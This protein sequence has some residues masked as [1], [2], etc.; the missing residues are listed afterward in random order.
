MTK[1]QKNYQGSL[2]QL[3]SM[4]PEIYQP[5]FN[6]PELSKTVSRDCYD[7]LEY[8][9]NI[10]LALSKKLNRPLNVLDLGC[11]QGFFSLSLAELGAKVHGVDY[12]EENIDVCNKLASNYEKLNLTFEHGKIEDILPK[13]NDGQ[14]D[15]VLGLSVFHHLVHEKGQEDVK[16]LLQ[17]LSDKIIASIFEFALS[18]EPLY[19]AEAQPENPRDLLRN[20]DFV[21][22]ISRNKTHLSEIERPLYFASNK[23]WYL[24]GKI[25]EFENAQKKSHIIAKDTHKNTRFYYFGNGLFIK[26]YFL[27]N[28]DL[29]SANLN[30]YNNEVEFLSNV[31]KG[32]KAPEL[33]DHGRNNH[34]LWV[35]RTLLPGKLLLDI[36]L[37]N[38]KY[39]AER[40]FREILDQLVLLESNGLYHSDLRLWNVLIDSE[41]RSCLIDYGA[42][43][44]KP[45]DCAWPENIILSFLIFM[46]ELFSA[47]IMETASYRPAWFNPDDLPEP[48]KQAVWNL[49]YSPV[50]EWS[51]SRLAKEISDARERQNNEKGRENSGLSFLL[52][53]MESAI[54]WQQE[55]WV[56]REIVI[57][58]LHYS[59]N[60]LRS[61]AD[62]QSKEL[63]ETKE[64]IK[65]FKDSS[66]YWQSLADKQSKELKE[67]K[68]KISELNGSSH[69]LQSLADRQFQELKETRAR[70]DELNNLSQNLQ[71]LY[72]KK[73]EELE[74]T[75]EKIEELEASCHHWKST[76]GRQASELEEAR[77]KI[78][79]LS[80][81]SHDWRVESERLNKE[82]HS[83]YQ[84]KSWRFTA[85]FRKARVAI[86]KVRF[87]SAGAK[88]NNFLKKVLLRAV[89]IIEKKPAFAKK[90]KQRISKYPWLRRKLTSIVY[91]HRAKSTKALDVGEI[92]RQKSDDAQLKGVKPT[93]DIYFTPPIE[94][95]RPRGQRTLFYYVDHTINCQNHTGVQNVV[96]RLLGALSDNGEKIVLVK[97]STQSKCFVR[98]E[99]SAKEELRSLGE[100]EEETTPITH[101]DIV[102]GDWLF[103]PEVTHIT[104]HKMDP[105]LD[106]ITEARRLGL[107]TAFIFYDAIPL[108][109]PE[110]QDVAERHRNYMQSLLLA[111]LIIP[112]SKYSGK[113]ILAYF[114][115]H[116]MANKSSLPEI[117]PISLPGETDKRKRKTKAS[118]GQSQKMILSVGTIEPRKKQLELVQAFQK[119]CDTNQNSDDWS[120]VLVG[121]LHPDVAKGI[122]DATKK[123]KKIK[124]LG[125]CEEDK[126]NELYDNCSFTVF[127]SV[128]EGFGLPI[129][130]SLWNGK[131]C[132]CASFGAMGEV[133]IGGGCYTVDKC[134]VECLEQ[135]ISRLTTDKDLLLYLEKQA[136]ERPITSWKDY[137][138]S[139]SDLLDQRS[140]PLNKLGK[141]YYWVDHTCSYNAN[142]GIQRVVRGLANSLINIGLELIPVKWDVQKEQFYS[143]SKTELEHLSRWNGPPVDSWAKW[144][145]PENA[146]AH[147]WL[148]IPELT[149]YLSRSTQNEVADYAKACGMRFAW[150]FYDNIPVKLAQLYPAEATNAHSAYMDD[151]TKADLIFP[152]SHHSKRELANY[153]I[154]RTVRTHSFSEK[155]QTCVLPGEF[156]EVERVLEIKKKTYKPIRIL[157]V[158]TIEP[159]KN[160]ACLLEA[161]KLASNKLSGN[162][163]LV[164]VGNDLFPDLSKL[165]ESYLQELPNLSWERSAD[166]ARLQELYNECD[167]TIYPS[168]EEGFGLPILESLWNARPCICA[169]FGA[170]LEVAKDGGCLTIDVTD[171]NAMS[172]AICK[173]AEDAML[174]VELSK[175][176]INRKFK[177]WDSYAIEM[178]TRMAKERH[179][180][181]KSDNF[182]QEEE[183]E[184]EDN[185]SQMI[186][187]QTR[188]LLSIC[189]STYNRAEWLKAC[190]ENLNHLLPK[191]SE[192]IEILVCDNAS[193]DNTSEVVK[194]YLTRPDF[195]YFRNEK[196]VGMLGNLRV[197]AHKAKGEYIWILGDD[198]LVMPDCIQ[199]IIEVIRSNPNT[200]LI[201]LNYSY[202]R[203]ERLNSHMSVDEFIRSAIPIVEPNSDIKGTVRDISTVSENF[204]TAIY[205]LVFRRDHALKA[206]S[207]NTAG[208]PF[209]TMQTCI[210]TTYYVLNYMMDESAYWLGTPQ[211]IVNMNVSWIKYAPLWILERIPEVHDLAE[212]MGA[213]SEKIDHWRRHNLMGVFH[214]WEEIFKNDEI[215]NG[216]Y[217]SPMRLVMRLKH[218]PEFTSEAGRLKAIYEDSHKQGNYIADIPTNTVFSVI[219]DVESNHIRKQ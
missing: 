185:Y 71:F 117:V 32:F 17:E 166:D 149:T 205:C 219:A 103:V 193:Q 214:Y 22:E 60:L 12:L 145:D 153:L 124:Y 30:E 128:E 2:E 81:S 62:R 186:N 74:K 141:I 150:I 6:N 164:L 147:D 76:I 67:T 101:A 208:R 20:F 7:R 114:C 108:K 179:V 176:A 37:N 118:D 163:E 16:L 167:F 104:S 61:T 18:T 75:K 158:A 40:V 121:N 165:V 190:L 110:M 195:N 25:G 31:P 152:I 93:A 191:P 182:Y 159:R 216:E 133:A 97:W 201:Y 11:A 183:C 187:L 175:Q 203:E 157:C 39:E 24:G 65:S 86:R 82:L 160:H 90:L 100:L 151:L 73:S 9:K 212:R 3:V 94:H 210:P 35:I 36:I 102:A 125:Y 23:Y 217:F 161:F 63:E 84:S 28:P 174:R 34:E 56:N 55:K 98:I 53:I 99:Q 156:S 211:L 77:Q 197:T 204:F 66:N 215:G 45:K 146:C 50:E 96:K 138:K 46:R 123:N 58:E 137:G 42:I 192:E 26:H 177:S 169:N 47:Q 168:I 122:I 88:K 112:I 95:F 5:I 10:Y 200:A 107:A 140:N 85:A 52:K 189:V 70:I 188:P 171:A 196:N 134:D 4:L 199:N 87:S 51:F 207:T 139:I 178:A 106:V 105:T 69:H 38:E 154:S 148:I 172:D 142:S 72:D 213:N 27:D 21:S 170:M 33:I 43:I 131:P 41:G 48:Y 120:L 129:L 198:D 130:E 162:I 194:P 113:E 14:Y 144:S 209:S 44:D 29:L 173:L 89:S 78:I 202:T 80:K 126:L 116:E 206:Y 49:I 119:F 111:D 155:V 64:K 57:D 8:I 127:P 68:E 1:S 181:S 83:V 91:Q 180:I 184:K 59:I 143:P 132:I 15:L 218:L 54:S 92:R 109:R 136:L 19:W 79:E 135:A 115:E 13:I